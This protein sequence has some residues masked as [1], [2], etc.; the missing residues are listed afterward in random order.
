MRV[1]FGEIRWAVGDA[2]GSCTCGPGKF[3]RFEILHRFSGFLMELQLEECL[4]YCRR[5]PL[6][7]CVD[8]CRAV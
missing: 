2:V 4:H 6:G 1:G 8:V 7:L 3:R 5:C